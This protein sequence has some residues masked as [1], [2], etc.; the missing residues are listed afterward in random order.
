MIALIAFTALGFSPLHAKSSQGLWLEGDLHAKRRVNVDVQHLSPQA[1]VNVADSLKTSVVNIS[2]SSKGKSSPTL[3]NDQGELF[4]QFFGEEF[5]ERFFQ[6]PMQP[7]GPRTQQSLGSGFVIHK[8]GYIV[9]NNHVVDK[10]DEIEV[11]FADETAYPAKLV[12]KDPKT[13]VALLKI[14]R[15]K[16]T[17]KPVIIGDSDQMK[18]GEI[19]I[20]IGNPFGLSNSITQGIIS[21]KERSIG[22]GTYDDFIQTDASINPGNS[23]GPLVNIHGEVIGINTAIVATGQGIGFAIP[24][25]LAKDIVNKLH[26]DGKVIRAW[27]GVL[28]QKVT[29]EHAKALGL[30]KKAGA[31]ISEIA[32]KGPAAKAGLKVGDVILSFNGKPI[33]DWHQLPILVATAEIGKTYT[34]EVF[35][36]EKVQKYRVKMEELKEGNPSMDDVSQS[37]TEEKEDKLGFIIEETKNDTRRQ[38][39]LPAGEG[40]TI[41]YVNPS[42]QAFEKGV[43]PG[44]II[45]TID[46]KQ[47][48]SIAEYRKVLQT[49]NKGQTVL[50]LVR[51]G[52]RNVYFAFTID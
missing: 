1:Y 22:F 15:K 47:I 45:R 42:S 7:E 41:K 16:S 9:T 23:G 18:V 38:A 28:I 5:F 40:V 43:R 20:A 27:L 30:S 11:V 31:L 39:D 13:D 48:T 21:A 35:R 25:N 8:D 50:L 46:K 2:T 36:D 12:G 3:P 34:V 32:E 14:E 26:Q 19:A 10:A 29:N 6:A 52:Q 24:I 4:N 37:K 51:R 33:S 49:L 44:D 17:F